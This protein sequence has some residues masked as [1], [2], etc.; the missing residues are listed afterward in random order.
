MTD[1]KLNL[2]PPNILVIL[3]DDLR[4]D[5]L[6]VNGHP[7]FKSPNINR[8]AK[9]G[10]QFQNAFVTHSLCSPSRAT[11]LTGLYSHQHRVLDNETPLN[12]RLATVAQLLHNA[13]YE[14]AFIGKW[15]MGFLDAMPKPGFDRWVSFIGQGKY[16]NPTINVD[17]E[18][19][20]ASGHMTDILTNYALEFLNRDRQKPFFLVLS[21]KAV[22]DPFT[23]QARFYRLYE[24]ANIVLPVTYGEDLSGKPAFLQEY[25]NFFKQDLRLRI[26]QYYECLAGV[27]E[28]VGKVLSKLTQKQLLKN[29][30]VI[31]TSDNGY[32]L[33]EHNVG[34]KRL[35]YEES[36]RVPL[37]VRYPP[38]FAAGAQSQ[39]FALNIDL[40]PTILE[41]AGIS[42]TRQLPGFSLRKLAN[43]DVQRKSFLY[44]YF[45]DSAVPMIPPMRAIRTPDFKY[46]RYFG[47]NAIDELYD[48]KNDSIE[49]RNLIDNPAFAGV[50]RRLRFQLDSLR[51]ATGDT[52]AL[53][54]AVGEQR[55]GVPHDFELYQNY[56][57]PLAA[58]GIY[59]DA[60][61][62]IRYALYKTVSIRLEIFD[63]TG[64]KVATLVEAVQGPGIR[65]INWKPSHHPSGVYLCRLQAGALVQTR[66]MVVL[67]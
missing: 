4:A 35:A 47:P 38:W 22:H 40:A 5:A 19:I 13:G 1:T 63:A 64:R 20:Q 52:S 57:N 59:G 49:T 23:I 2:T 34:D 62:T 45:F 27:D 60:V 50:L 8:I 48:L 51:L 44:Q 18:K 67:R 17:G 25:R 53:D 42:G 56:P 7:F 41:A 31:F 33:G 55:S 65:A 24:N 11:L 32:I 54:T 3:I 6:G 39:T 37:F 43:G 58:G 28:G 26:Q 9:E 14:T 15:H 46:I 66:K 12:S 36:I 30:L 10:V 61:T 16:L 21:H 29:T